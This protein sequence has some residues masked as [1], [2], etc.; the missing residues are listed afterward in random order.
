MTRENVGERGGSGLEKLLPS[1]VIWRAE[2]CRPSK[3]HVDDAH[4]ASVK[5]PART[6]VRRERRPGYPDPRRH[7]T[8]DDRPGYCARAKGEGRTV[9]ECG[10]P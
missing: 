6:G 2:A 8:G 9:T 10:E 4:F 1:V 3:T 5:L 7:V